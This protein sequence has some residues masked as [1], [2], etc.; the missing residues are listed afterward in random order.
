MQIT[1]SHFTAGQT[2]LLDRALPPLSPAKP[3]LSGGMDGPT[4]AFK[5]MVDDKG[6]RGK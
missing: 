4:F 2:L 1:A 3:I 6:A 5:R